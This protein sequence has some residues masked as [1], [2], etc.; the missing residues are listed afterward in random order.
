MR[1]C[2][3]MSSNT[4]IHISS[5]LHISHT[6]TSPLHP[7]HNPDAC[8][9]HTRTPPPPQW[10]LEVWPALIRADASAS[11]HPCGQQGPLLTG[12]QQETCPLWCAGPPHGESHDSCLDN[13][14]LCQAGWFFT[15]ELWQEL[16]SEWRSHSRASARRMHHVRRVAKPWRTASATMATL[17]WSYQCST[18]GTS[19]TLLSYYRTS[20]RFS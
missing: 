11:T 3:L 2:T 5:A 20:A 18:W 1:L 19:A 14:K 16:I 9:P 6:C 4:H 17:T 13:T 10:P 8:T 15:G 12:Q 7:P